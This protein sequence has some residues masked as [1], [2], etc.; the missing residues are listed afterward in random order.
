MS[1]DANG[2]IITLNRTNSAGTAIANYGYTYQAK[3][4]KLTSVSGYSTSFAYDSL[5]Q[6]VTQVRTAGSQGYYLDYDVN[7]KVTIVYSNPAK[8][9]KRVSFGYDESGNKIRKTDH[10]LNTITYYV[11]DASGNLLAVY[12]NKGTAMGQKEVPIYAA[13]RLG[14]YNRAGNSYQYEL[15]DHLGNVRVVINGTKQSNGQ[16]DVVY[17]SDYYPFGSPLTLATNDYRYGYQG[18]YA[19]VD[20]ETGWNNFE[21]RMYDPAIGRWMTTD[22]YGQYD[23]P[24]VGMG[25]NPVSSVDPD[26][27]L[28]G[29]PE[30]PIN[31]SKPNQLKEV[32]ITL[33]KGFAGG[34]NSTLDW[35]KNQFTWNGM[36]DNLLNQATFGTYGMMKS[37]QGGYQMAKNIPNYTSN[38][39]IYATGFVVEKVA[40]AFVFK[41]IGS[42]R[43]AG[44]VA[45]TKAVVVATPTG[46]QYSVVYETTL[47][48]TS[49]PGVYRGAHFLEANKALSATMASDAGFASAM[50]ELG[51]VVPRSPTGAI[52]GTSPVN[53]VWHHNVAPGV[54]QLV[55]KA[56]HTAGSSFWGTLH[57]NGRGGFAIWG[58]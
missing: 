3:T 36:R 15:T 27:G 32:V 12:D 7:G 22:P 55:P 31:D 16:A 18:Q 51:V 54:M 4:N 28:D 38:D 30:K 43:A 23:S 50:N 17:Y 21:L 13:S 44:I 1:Y 47:S 52:S 24:Y 49:Y 19:E 42:V 48:S 34:V 9:I 14:M 45:E 41:R 25:N 10:I 5:G 26:G 11:N 39:Y 29:D 57:P 20:K 8:T 37:I 33:A 35:A 53:F 40:E 6:M 46:A 56:Q 2:N 58:K